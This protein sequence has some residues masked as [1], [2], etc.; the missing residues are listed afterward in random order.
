MAVLTF[1]VDRGAPLNEPAEPL[2]VDN[3]LGPW[4]NRQEHILDQVDEPAPI[5]VG[6]GDQGRP[7]VVV[8]RQLPSL[9]R[10][11]TLDQRL[12]RGVI[13]PLESQ[14][15]GPGQK[16][17]I[18]LE[19]RV[20]RGRADQHDRA[21][22][23]MGQEGILLR[24]VEAMDLVDE[25][26]R[27]PPRLAL[28]LGRIE[29]FAQIRDARLDRRKLLEMKVGHLGQKACDGGLAG[30]RRPPEDHRGQTA[31]P[32]HAAEKPITQEMILADDFVQGLGA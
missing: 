6:H 19:G 32:H 11:G 13:Q 18:Q 29:D 2:P 9:M 17:R 21:V 10:L 24:A 16:R 25:Q 4:R 5:A 26:Q 27:A 22:F 28:G 3:G 1:V 7:G 15:A 8:E 12:E 31:C 20:L 23:H 14:H 30:P